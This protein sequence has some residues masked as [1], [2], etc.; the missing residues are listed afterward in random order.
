MSKRAKSNLLKYGISVA[1]V[2]LMAGYYI[3]THDFLNQVRMEQY[4]IICDAFTIPGA[5]LLLMGAMVWLS[6]EGA[7]SAIGYAGSWLIRRLIPGAALGE[8]E[9]YGEYMERKKEKRVSGYGFLFRV[10][11]ISM[12]IALINM[13]LFYR[14]YL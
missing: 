14:L 6:N 4:R 3:G 8:R 12:A 9:T 7:L 5:L 13:I 10:G 2:I 11:G 1:V